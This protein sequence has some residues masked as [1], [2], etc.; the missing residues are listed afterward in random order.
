MEQNNDCFILSVLQRARHGHYRG[1][2]VPGETLPRGTAAA[3]DDEDEDNGDLK[4]PLEQRAVERDAYEM[5]ASMIS[6]DSS[7]PSPST[8]KNKNDQSIQEP[9]VNHVHFDLVG[10]IQNLER[11]KKRAETVEA[12]L[13]SG[14]SPVGSSRQR[15]SRSDTLTGHKL[16]GNTSY[17]SAGLNYGRVVDDSDVSRQPQSA[18]SFLKDSNQSAGEDNYGIL[19]EDGLDRTE[20][21][22]TAFNTLVSAVDELV[23]K[24]EQETSAIVEQQKRI[25]DDMKR[26]VVERSPGRISLR[27]SLNTPRVS[28][29]PMST[30]STPRSARVSMSSAL[31]SPCQNMTLEDLSPR[32]LSIS[33][34]MLDPG[35]DNVFERLY[36]EA[37]RFRN[38]RSVWGENRAEEDELLECTFSPRIGPRSRELSQKIPPLWKRQEEL[39]QKRESQLE[40]IRARMDEEH[41]KANTFSPRI[42]EMSQSHKSSIT[43]LLHWKREREESLENKRRQKEE[44]SLEKLTFSPRLSERTIQLANRRRSRERSKTPLSARMMMMVTKSPRSGNEKLHL[45]HSPTR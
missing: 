36:R 39:Q 27:R 30:L 19:I 40:S 29:S 44:G 15:S 17:I 3:D 23:S 42:S 9:G 8:C 5:N 13:G 35:E 18:R 1:D 16:D 2:L 32:S 26:N 41:A 45:H 7:V 20:K 38:A 33:L 4:E 43:A 34:D 14:S 11:E 6:N 10:L 28:Q 37:P 22:N 21:F 31:S 24:E 25:Y 12:V